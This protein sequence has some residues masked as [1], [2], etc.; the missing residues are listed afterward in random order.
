MLMMGA[1][2]QLLLPA[3]IEFA[4][5]LQFPLIDLQAAHHQPVSAAE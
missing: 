3:V 1:I 5:V 4:T 2:Q